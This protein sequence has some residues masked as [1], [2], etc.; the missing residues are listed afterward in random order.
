MRSDQLI[1]LGDQPPEFIPG[2]TARETLRQQLER[3][4]EQYLAA[5]GKI[6]TVETVPVSHLSREDRAL[7]MLRR[8]CSP[9]E[10]AHAL[11]LQ[12]MAVRRLKK[13]VDRERKRAKGQQVEE[14]S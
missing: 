3:D 10:V 11:G 6:Q 4:V 9:K 13:Q 1:R 14:Q 5:G 2:V 12:G 8:G 7:E